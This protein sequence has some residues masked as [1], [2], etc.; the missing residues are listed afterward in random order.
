MDSRPASLYSRHRTWLPSTE[1]MPGGVVS[2]RGMTC[3]QRGAN[4][5][6]C[7]GLARSGGLPGMPRSGRRGPLIEGKASMSPAV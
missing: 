4:R 6:P 1:D 3:G 7:G 5:Q 2:H